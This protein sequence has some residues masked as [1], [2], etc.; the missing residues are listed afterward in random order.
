MIHH[1]PHLTIQCPRLIQ[2]DWKR[3]VRQAGAVFSHMLC[4]F[5]EAGVNCVILIPGNQTTRPGGFGVHQP[6]AN[7]RRILFLE[8][9]RPLVLVPLPASVHLKHIMD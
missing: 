7:A 2:L 3:D 9:S 8:V 1:L 6:I 5:V 4:F